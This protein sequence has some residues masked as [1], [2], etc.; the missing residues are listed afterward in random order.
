MNTILKAKMSNLKEE[1]ADNERKIA[2]LKESIRAQKELIAGLKSKNDEQVHGNLKEIA[3]SETLIAEKQ[4]ELES[5][6]K[7]IAEVKQ[8][9]QGK[10][11]LLKQISKLETL[12][13]QLESN[14]RKVG[15][16]L[17]FFD[18]N[19]VC[20]TCHQSIDKASNPIHSL[21]C[22]KKS[23]QGELTEAVGAIV[24]EIDTKRKQIE[25]YE[26]V[27]SELERLNTETMEANS[28]ITA[29][30]SY[31][32]KLTKE[33]KTIQSKEVADT[34]HQK[35]LVDFEGDLN[36][37]ESSKHSLVEEMHY[38]SVAATL[39]KDSG[40]KAK[41]IRYYLP[42]INKTINKYL[43]T[44]DFFANFTLDDE[45]NETI[46]SRHRDAFSYMSFSEGEKMRIDLALLLAWREIARIKNS[47]NT[48]LLILDEVFDSS[49]DTSG[50]EEFMKILHSFGANS[51]VFVISHKADQL[52][53]KFEHTMSFEK[54]NNFSRI[55]P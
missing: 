54:K 11:S 37:N 4:E 43:N 48:N 3:R 51:N 14:R 32:S 2:I 36:K 44:M 17:A 53:D 39:L 19:E 30:N 1:I 22:K 10:V 23:K 12:Q 47:A 20:P 7:Q 16:E 21:L 29:C 55:S 15:D 52:V 5:L 50:T 28:T 27:S 42:I 35:R 18:N 6:T 8:Q 49:L 40:I 38:Y 9:L 46:K 26:V 45:F 25:E 31:I 34:D 33:N 24:D 13:K 41:I